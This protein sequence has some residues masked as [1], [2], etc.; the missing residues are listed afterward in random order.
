MLPWVFVR[1]TPSGPV[2]KV[3]HAVVGVTPVA[4]YGSGLQGRRV[5]FA[6]GACR[7]QVAAPAGA[8][9]GCVFRTPGRYVYRLEGVAARG[10]VVVTRG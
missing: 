9:S 10:V 7:T 8:R 6:R 2:P 4:W 3:A 1:V 5:V